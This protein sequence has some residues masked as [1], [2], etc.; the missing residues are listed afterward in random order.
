MFELTSALL[1]LGGLVFYQPYSMEDCKFFAGI[2]PLTYPGVHMIRAYR[3]QSKARQFNCFT[4]SSAFASNRNL[5]G[6]VELTLANGSPMHSYMQLLDMAGVTFPIRCDDAGTGGSA[7][8]MSTA[9]RV[10]N[11]PEWAKSARSDFVVY[12][13]SCRRLAIV[14]GVRR[15][16]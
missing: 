14:G 15:R 11:T 2:P 6:F 5:N 10:V 16:I 13:M 7:F 4:G 3:T 8:I 12:T 1:N 9:C